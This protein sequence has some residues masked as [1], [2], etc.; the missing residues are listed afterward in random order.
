MDDE[1]KKKNGEGED[2]DQDLEDD[3]LDEDEL[4]EDGEDD[5]DEEEKDSEDDDEEKDEDD[6]EEDEEDGDFDEKDLED[7]AKR[8]EAVALLKKAKSAIKQ[9]AIWKKRALKAG[10][11]K[12]KQT[13]PAANLKKKTSVSKGNEVLEA[14]TKLNELT[15]F[16]LDHPDL[17][18]KMVSEIQ[19]YA[20]ANEM[21][22]EKALRRPLI[23]RY[24]NDKALKE[25]L[26]KASISSGHRST[27]TKPT[28]DWS[29]ATPQEVAEHEREVRERNRQ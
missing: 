17:P 29:K 27:Q 13:P 14:A 2:S 6:D 9:R 21:T 15:N 22:L 18:R 3:E 19:K 5:E 8:A 7:P 12:E 16:R 11:G 23:Q 28:K 1:D 25:R 20:S 26:S 4:D 10:H 24:V